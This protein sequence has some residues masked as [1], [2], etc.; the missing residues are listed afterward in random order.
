MMAKGSRVAILVA[1]LALGLMYVLPVWS[2]ELEAPQYPEGLGMVIRIN[3]IEG[4]KEHDLTNIN[5]LNH[6]I[7]MQ[8]IVP[9]SIPE[10]DLMPKIVAV[11]MVLGVLTAALESLTRPANDN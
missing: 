6:Y 3:T 5:R 2:I 1:S 7:G 10:L 8:E 4:E 9:E 11:L